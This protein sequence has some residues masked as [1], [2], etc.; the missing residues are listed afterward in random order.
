[1]SLFINHDH[2]P[3]VFKN[4]EN[5]HAFNQGFVKYH[6]LTE[7]LNK[8]Q[9]ASMELMRSIAEQKSRYGQQEVAQ[10]GQWFRLTIK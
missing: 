7:L 2:H 8:Q 6:Y 4:Q 3:N 5:V 10:K 9:K 1:M